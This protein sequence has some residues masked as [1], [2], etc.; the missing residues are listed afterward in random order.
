MIAHHGQGLVYTSYRWLRQFLIED[1]AVV[2]YCERGA[3]DNLKTRNALRVTRDGDWE[4]LEWLIG[5]QMNYA[6][7]E[8]RHSRLAYRSP[9]EYRIRGGFIPETLVKSGG[10]ESTH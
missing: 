8:R 9:I 7:C 2:P 3:K 5:R 10:S 1:K 6:G 4:E